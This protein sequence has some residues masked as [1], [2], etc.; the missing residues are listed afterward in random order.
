MKSN[1]FDLEHWEKED[2]ER[3]NDYLVSISNPDRVEW[4][5]K[6]VNT[7]LREF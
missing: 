5:T 3:L 1:N 6:I 4:L 7:N 2:I